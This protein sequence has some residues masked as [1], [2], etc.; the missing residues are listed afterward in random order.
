ML[1]IFLKQIN[2]N[3]CGVVVVK[4][5]TKSRLFSLACQGALSLFTVNIAYIYLLV[6]IG[7]EYV[8]NRRTG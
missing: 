1:A 2:V 7:I 5:N 8:L 4:I 6:L 3:A